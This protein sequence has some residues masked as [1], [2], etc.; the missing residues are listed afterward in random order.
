M[1]FSGML[2]VTQPNKAYFNNFEG[3]LGFLAIGSQKLRLCF[4][5]KPILVRIK[6][7]DQEKVYCSMSKTHLK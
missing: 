5:S 4:T 3:L 2:K 7:Q 1:R 6:S